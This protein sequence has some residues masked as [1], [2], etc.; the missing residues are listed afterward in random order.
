MLQSEITRAKRKL[1]ISLLCPRTRR[2]ASLIPAAVCYA[3]S[4]CTPAQRLSKPICDEHCLRLSSRRR[5]QMSLLRSLH[6][7]L[8][9]KNSSYAQFF[10][11]IGSIPR[12][13][14]GSESNK[15]VPS[16]QF[17]FRIEAT[18]CSR[19]MTPWASSLVIRV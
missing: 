19:A 2:T 1:A 3:K 18:S 4:T 15:R 13:I 10:G 16:S 7:D 11:G 17:F 12:K 5:R 14:S 9:V 6:Y 8:K